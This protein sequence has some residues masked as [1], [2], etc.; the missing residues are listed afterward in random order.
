[1]IK[2][3]I[4]VILIGSFYFY[5]NN[6]FINPYKEKIENEEEKVNYVENFVKEKWE[7]FKKY[8]PFHS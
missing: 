4:I 3:S 6:T 7:S 5:I 1:M 2:I 8:N